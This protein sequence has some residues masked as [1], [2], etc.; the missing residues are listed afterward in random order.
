M[1]TA[2]FVPICYHFKL[3]KTMLYIIYGK[4]AYNQENLAKKC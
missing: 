4:F 3:V 2:M 1:G